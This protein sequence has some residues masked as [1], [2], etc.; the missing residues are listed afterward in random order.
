MPAPVRP[1]GR[2]GWDP[3]VRLT[4]W[5]IALAILVNGALLRDGTVAHVWIGYA[6]LSALILRL[7][8]GLIAPGPAALA[9]MPLA[10]SR[11]LAHLRDLVAW[12]WHDSPGHTPLGAWMAV[13]I[14]SLLAVTAVTG[15]VLEA[16]PFP[17]DD[18]HHAW[19][20]YRYDHDDD[21][22][23]EDDDAHETGG[24]GAEVAEDLHEA[25]AT[26]LLILAALHV[27]GV[28]LESRLSGVNLAKGMIFNRRERTK[29]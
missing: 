12:R 15:L 11:A 6:A 27:A 8:W 2:R 29:R 26:G 28:G 13:A 25:A 20:D 24:A 3:L 19:S 22:E 4:H 7:L 10:P 5:T 1:G 17:D 16:D 14:W 21:E 9:E 23:D 18:T